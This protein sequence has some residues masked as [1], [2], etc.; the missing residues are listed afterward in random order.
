[1]PLSL[2]TL[3]RLAGL[4]LIVFFCAAVVLSQDK[5]VVVDT[6][7]EEPPQQLRSVRTG[8]GNASLGDKHDET[9]GSIVRGRAFYEDT[10]KPV[11]R[12]WIGFIKIRELVEKN[13]DNRSTAIIIGGGSYSA[14]KYVL[15]NDQGE[16]VIKGVKAGIYLPT[17]K[18]K[19]VLNPDYSDRQNPRFQQIPVDGTNEVEVSVGVRRGGSIS[20]RILYSDGEPVIGAKVQ[21]FIKRE[22]AIDSYYSY[23]GGDSLTVT[24]TDDRGFYRFAGLPANEYFVRVVEPSVHSG[25]G[26]SVSSYE[27]TQ[28]DSGSELKTFYPSV[29]SIKEAKTVAVSPGLEQSDV[30][31]RIPDRRL[32]RISGTAIAKNSKSPLRGLKVAFEKVGDRQAGTYSSGSNDRSKQTAT[33]EQGGW[34]FKDLP[35][36]KYRITVSMEDS[37]YYSP[38]ER[39]RRQQQQ[40]RQQAD[41]QPKYAPL[42]KEIEIED[43][44]LQDLSF[45]LAPEATIS[46]T[47]VVEGDKPFPDYVSITVFDQERKLNSSTFIG[48]D[49]SVKRDGKNAS[50][51]GKAPRA[52]RIDRLSEG[53][54]IFNV[55]SDSGYYIKSVKMGNTDLMK[56]P[57]EL[58]DGQDVTGV[59]IVLGTD[60]GI[61]K[62]KIKDYKPGR[63]AFVAVIPVDA[64]T[65]SIN[66]MQRLDVDTVNPN[67]EFELKAAP[68]E[69]FVV[70]ETDNNN[71][72]DPEKQS[73]AQWLRD[74]VKGA[75]KVTLKSGVTETISLDFPANK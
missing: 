74:L 51:D 32:F 49:G 71:K 57:L 38:S 28:Y 11:R 1:M 69:Y 73:L 12:G 2:Q 40:Q 26:K 14:E 59:Q 33:D 15:T 22:G 53:D 27:M 55:S 68:G 61:L 48:S 37:D 24:V 46:G 8:I 17:L 44:D 18:V 75:P 36:G 42:S 45:E 43:K 3:L 63:R 13:E 20:G 58:K 6:D 19:G 23:S 72:L 10:G 16:F 52:F 62:G 60:V 54:F 67:G 21:I 39:L 34:A 9:G 70:I 50:D 41:S 65:G 25:A 35:K 64:V 66:A 5:D 4:F 31:I 29:S 7:D 47:V 30:D 56:S